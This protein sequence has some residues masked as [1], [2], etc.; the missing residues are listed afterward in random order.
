MDSD[1]P[2]TPPPAAQP[3]ETRSPFKLKPKTDFVVTNP[4]IPRGE[5]SPAHDV[6]ALRQT[7]GD[8]TRPPVPP[9]GSP[10]LEFPDLEP[11]P[12][13]PNKKLRD[14]LVLMIGGNGVL[15]LLTLLGWGDPFLMA[16]GV[17]GMACFSLALTWV[18][19][20][21]MGRY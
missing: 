8:G 16:C 10:E 11:L 19:W 3:G 1:S 20:G 14:Y 13:R 15:G 7:A 21:V 18:M 17:G 6:W 12:V 5:T 9:P 4:P 2:P